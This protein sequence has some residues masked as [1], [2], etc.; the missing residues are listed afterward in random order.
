MIELYGKLRIQRG[1]S[2]H[3]SSLF[4]FLRKQD[5]YKEPIKPKKAYHLQPYDTPKMIGQKWQCDVKYVP[6]HC[7]SSSMLNDQKFYQN[8]MI[9]EVSRERF[10]YH[11][12]EHSSYS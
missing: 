6:K 12:G 7:K 11:Y 4:R 2:R 10:I 8:T 3:P 1:Y 5:F 9:D